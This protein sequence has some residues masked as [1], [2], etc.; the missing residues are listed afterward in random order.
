MHKG[1]YKSF[2]KKVWRFFFRL[3][4][5]ILKGSI[6]SKLDDLYNQVFKEFGVPVAH[7]EKTR[8]LK[9]ETRLRCDA[10][11]KNDKTLE[12][13][14]NIE[15]ETRETISREGGK[16]I[17][18]ERSLSNINLEKGTKYNMNNT[19]VSEYYNIINVLNNA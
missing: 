9:A 12:V 3:L 8:S 6:E 14:A 18:I 1:H 15:A 17:S 7:L 11:L 2:F 19:T 5:R 13:L 4:I 10:I 16:G